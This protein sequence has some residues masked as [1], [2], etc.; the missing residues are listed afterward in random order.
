MSEATAALTGDT[1]G[2][3][4][5]G[6]GQGGAP[7]PLTYEV[8]EWAKSF[9]PELQDWVGKKG[10]KDVGALVKSYRSLEQT[11][12]ADRAG[13]A[14]ILPDGD[15]P[16]AWDAVWKRMGRPDTPD[17]YGIKA[18]E[19]DDGKIAA[20]MSE[21]FHKAG[22]TPKQAQAIQQWIH[23]A[24]SS[25]EGAVAAQRSAQSTADVTAL[26]NEW[27]PNYDAKV[28]LGRRA[29]RVMGIDAEALNKIEDA[30]GTRFVFERFAAAGEWLREDAGVGATA[31]GTGN[32]MQEL[33]AKR[34]DPEF[35]RRL[36]SENYRERE[37]AQAELSEFYKR[38]YPPEV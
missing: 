32:A 4:P 3:A 22:L 38:A 29:A 13:K 2:G 8:P 7:G 28:E 34:D 27:G 1:G 11:F 33:Q 31:G 20:A 12:G 9:E 10:A 5:A 14:V 36:N 19:G 16:A 35:R 25:D 17:A 30:L 24:G 18:A 21:A 23:E 6:G 37:A 15:D 26:R